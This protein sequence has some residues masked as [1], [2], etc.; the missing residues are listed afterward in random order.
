[1]PGAVVFK[2]QLEALAKANQLSLEDWRNLLTTS[3]QAVSPG[4]RTLRPL[5]DWRDLV[6]DYLRTMKG[7]RPGAQAGG[8]RTA[9]EVEGKFSK[10]NVPP[11]PVSPPPPPDAGSGW[12]WVAIALAGV[13]LFACGY[14]IRDRRST[15]APHPEQ[16]F[17]DKIE[18][19]L[20]GA[21]GWVKHLQTKPTT[22]PAWD[23]IEALAAH[24][25]GKVAVFRSW[26]E[27]ERGTLPPGLRRA[28]LEEQHLYRQLR[29]IYALVQAAGLEPTAPHAQRFVYLASRLT[30]QLTLKRYGGTVCRL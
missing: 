25:S 20:T 14:L 16:E 30:Q 22:T 12:R 9:P 5:G 23:A 8:G 18:G 28:E 3:G 21:E 15:P 19:H 11:V 1:M 4:L 24:G 27:V 17:Q 2:D 7:S 6:R 13:I 29:E 10:G 26:D